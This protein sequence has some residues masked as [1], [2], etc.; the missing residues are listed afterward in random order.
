MKLLEAP[1]RSSFE[2]LTTYHPASGMRIVDNDILVLRLRTRMRGS[3]FHWHRVT[4]SS[5]VLRT[6]SWTILII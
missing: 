1:M 6:S 5:D 2:P 3:G 4:H